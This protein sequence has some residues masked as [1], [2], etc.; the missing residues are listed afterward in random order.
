MFNIPEH[1][2]MFSL[3]FFVVNIYNILMFENWRWSVLYFWRFTGV[4]ASCNDVNSNLCL[5]LSNSTPT[6]DVRQ[7]GKFTSF[8][9]FSFCQVRAL[10]IY[11]DSRDIC[12][13]NDVDDTDYEPT[14]ELWSGSH[15]T[16]FIILVSQH[17]I[18]CLELEEFVQF[19]NLRLLRNKILKWRNE[20][21]L[22]VWIIDIRSLNFVHTLLF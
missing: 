6:P 3:V 9:S 12:H 22:K 2:I 21:Y 8:L 15:C 1:F 17:W 10:T 18:L 7:K 19:S 13:L 5:R 16:Y 14:T 11:W 20:V 4:F